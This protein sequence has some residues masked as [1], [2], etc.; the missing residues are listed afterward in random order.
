[1]DGV[2][3]SMSPGPAWPTW[4]LEKKK[5]FWLATQVGPSLQLY[6]SRLPQMFLLAP[7]F[8]VSK[9]PAGHFAAG[10]PAV[11]GAR[12]SAGPPSG[13]CASAG[14]LPPAALASGVALAS[15]GEPPAPPV[16]ATGLVPPPVPPEPPLPP[17][18]P[19]RPPEPPAALLLPPLPPAG[20]SAPLGAQ[21]MT[22][23]TVSRR[24]TGR[25]RAK[26]SSPEPVAQ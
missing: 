8:G 23:T 15:V 20:E 5:A 19:P 22:K 18:P 21:D 9:G 26:W 24:S 16:P 11:S 1:M 4:K 7:A 14:P 17:L 10:L 12:L 3:F 2:Y 6:L 13:V 25:M